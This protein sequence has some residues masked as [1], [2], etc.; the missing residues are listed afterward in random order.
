MFKVY[1]AENNE[2]EVKE[3]LGKVLAIL[4][5]MPLANAMAL[6]MSIFSTTLQLDDQCQEE[7]R[8]SIKRSGERRGGNN[9]QAN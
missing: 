2:E 7:M 5:T 1:T 6:I 4:Q 8:E 9:E 3:K